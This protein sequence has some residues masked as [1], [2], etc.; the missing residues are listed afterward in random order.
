MSSRETCLVQFVV[1]FL[2]PGNEIPCNKGQYPFDDDSL[3]DFSDQHGLIDEEYIKIKEQ[4][5]SPLQDIFEVI[6]PFVYL[7]PIA[8]IGQDASFGCGM[9]MEVENTSTPEVF[10]QWVKDII[11]LAEPE[12]EPEPYKPEKF[13]LGTL[14]IEECMI[15]NDPR[16]P[17]S[18]SLTTVWDYRG[19]DTQGYYDD[20]PE[21]EFEW[22]LLGKVDFNKIIKKK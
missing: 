14:D 18:I 16:M 2:K 1:E 19:Y 5:I 22:D 9:K 7:Y 20:Y 8:Y 10:G 13:K 17:I 12:P 6:K 21:W 15:T 11:A 4:S 3:F